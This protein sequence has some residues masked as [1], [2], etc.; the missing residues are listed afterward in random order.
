MYATSLNS[1]NTLYHIY[2]IPHFIEEGTEAEKV[3]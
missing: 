1:Q 3:K 2:Y